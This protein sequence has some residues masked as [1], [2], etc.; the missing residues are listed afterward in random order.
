MTS[1]K[2]RQIKVVSQLP[3]RKRFYFVADIFRYEGKEGE[4][5]DISIL[6][7]YS[8]GGTGVVALNVFKEIINYEEN[9]NLDI[10]VKTEEL[11]NTLIKILE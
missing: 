10:L 2:T 1:S 3:K 11:K 9:K 5:E 4:S 7:Y 6:W 8:V